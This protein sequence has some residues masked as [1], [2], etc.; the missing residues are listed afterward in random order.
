MED[1]ISVGCN[2]NLSVLASDLGTQTDYDCTKTLK[3]AALGDD[4][5]RRDDDDGVDGVVAEGV[6]AHLVVA[7]AV[8]V[9]AAVAGD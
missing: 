6:R 9:V 5:E 1:L 7:V 8:G 2:P 4:D 3:V